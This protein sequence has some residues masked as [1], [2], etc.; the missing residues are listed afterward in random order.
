MS[1]AAQSAPKPLLQGQDWSGPMGEKWNHWH[2]R[3]E[4][5]L[6]PIGAATLELAG[7]RNGERVLD[8]GCGA[9]ATT[10]ALARQVGPGGQVLGVDISSVLVQ[11]A[12]GAR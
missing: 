10:L 1:S 5:M 4:A 6:A 12:A 9:G 3:F 8:I 11:T 2:E 7:C